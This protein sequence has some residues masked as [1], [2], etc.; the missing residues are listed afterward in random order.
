MLT[1]LSRAKSMFG[2]PDDDQSRDLELT[3]LISAASGAIENYCRRSFGLKQY[4][5]EKYDGIKGNNLSLQ[6]YPIREISSVAICNSLIT[7]YEV[8]MERGMLFRAN[9][10]IAG[11]R[12]IAVTYTAGYVLPDDA[13]EENPSTLP[14]PLELACLLYAQ[15][16]QRQPGVTAER[17][18]DLSVTYANDGIG[19][20]SPVKSLISPYRRW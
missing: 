7:D 13:T 8:I 15:M 19:L 14:E 1:T 5:E 11:Q 9:G 6:Q 17:V 4:Q 10:W 20:P 3:L 12:N 2:I 18:G 16:L